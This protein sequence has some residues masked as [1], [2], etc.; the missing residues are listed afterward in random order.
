MGPASIAPIVIG[1][2]MLILI[3]RVIYSAM[4]KFSLKGYWSHNPYEALPEWAVPWFRATLV[5][6]AIGWAVGIIFYS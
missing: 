5:V 6:L 1:T 2:T 3:G 4:R